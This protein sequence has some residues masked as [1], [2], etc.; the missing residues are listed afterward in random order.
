MKIQEK[1]SYYLQHK[2]KFIAY[3]NLDEFEGTDFYNEKQFKRGSKW[4]LSGYVDKDLMLPIGEAEI[5]GFIFNSDST[6]INVD[7]TKMK[8]R[9]LLT[10]LEY[11]LDD[12]SSWIYITEP[13]SFDNIES[14]KG[15][16]EIMFLEPLNLPFAVF[17]RILALHGDVFDLIGAGIAVNKIVN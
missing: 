13:E 12:V 6:Y 9:P 5:D 11:L 8:L 2:L 14:A 10:P 15:W 3:K 7:I 4:E 17:N 1:Y 16:C